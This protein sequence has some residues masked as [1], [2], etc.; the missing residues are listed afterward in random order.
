MIQEMSLVT[1]SPLLCF[2]LNDTPA[3]FFLRLFIC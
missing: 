1:L 3:I 2:P